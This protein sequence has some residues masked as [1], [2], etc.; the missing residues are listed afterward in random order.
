MSR[1]SRETIWKTAEERCNKRYWIVR[2]DRAEYL[3][4]SLRNAQKRN[5]LWA[6]S[7]TV[8]EIGRTDGTILGE[9]YC[10]WAPIVAV[11]SGVQGRHRAMIARFRCRNE[12]IAN[13][14][15]KKAKDKM[16]TMRKNTNNKIKNTREWSGWKDRSRQEIARRQER[17]KIWMR[18][19]MKRRRTERR[20]AKD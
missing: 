14:Y 11:R 3:T 19:I 2:E 1:G 15:W 12:K 17:G 4:L 20:K 18:K 13:R 6:A 7:V 5:A 9:R 8:G 16:Y 10:G